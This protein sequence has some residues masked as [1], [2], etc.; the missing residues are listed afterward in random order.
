MDNNGNVEERIAALELDVAALKQR[1]G[2]SQRDWP[3]RLF[4]RMRDF[5]EKDFKE[6]VRF[7]KEFRDSQT[8]PKNE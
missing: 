7:G 2:D 6:F 3:D 8:D 5:P 4:G 1:V